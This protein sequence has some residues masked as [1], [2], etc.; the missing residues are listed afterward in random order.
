MAE[1]FGGAAD[2]IEVALTRAYPHE[3]E[4]G[5]L[6]DQTGLNAVELRGGLAVLRRTGK[7]NENGEGFALQRNG[8]EPARVPLPSGEAETAEEPVPEGERPPDPEGAVTRAAA[9]GAPG[10]GPTF[11]AE[12]RLRMA[13]AGARGESNEAAWDEGLSVE[14]RI[15]DLLAE[16]LGVGVSVELTELERATFEKVTP[17]KE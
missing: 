5:E 4:K 2:Q 11:R 12:Y 6:A 17:P 13:F 7:L 16:G 15:A 8:D 9:L 1:D 14:T 3:L 10:S